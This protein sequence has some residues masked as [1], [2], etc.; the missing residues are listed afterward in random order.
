MIYSVQDSSVILIA[1]Y[2]YFS[3]L[4]PQQTPVVLQDS[5]LQPVI[6]LIFNRTSPG[7]VICYNLTLVSSLGSNYHLT[8]FL[9]LWIGMC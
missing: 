4:I 6:L 1:K 2:L 8:L 3:R 5:I 7:I 9:L